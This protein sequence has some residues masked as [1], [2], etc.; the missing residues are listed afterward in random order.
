MKSNIS[1]KDE[2][3]KNSNLRYLSL[4]IFHKNK[5]FELVNQDYGYPVEMLIKKIICEKNHI[6]SYPP[7]T[8]KG[9][10]SPRYKTH[11]LNDLIKLSGLSCKVDNLRSNDFEFYKAWL[12]VCSWDVNNRY[13]IVGF[14]EETSEDYIKVV[15]KVIEE[16][17]TWRV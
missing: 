2:L 15:K 7:R 16:V 10:I 11:D 4:E 6:H 5:L 14:N 12:K 8:N 1:S 9:C 17:R 13:K 3:D